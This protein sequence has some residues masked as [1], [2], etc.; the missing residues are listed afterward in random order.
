MADV[1]DVLK[2]LERLV[3]REG[4]PLFEGDIF[5][6]LRSSR[7]VIHSFEFALADGAVD[8]TCELDNSAS[9]A[10]RLW[11]VISRGQG[12]QAS[13]LGLFDV[14]STVGGLPG[15]QR[16]C[17]TRLQQRRVAFYIGISA[18]DPT[19]VEVIPNLFQDDQVL[20]HTPD[21]A[22]K[23]DDMEVRVNVSRCSRLPPSASGLLD[24]CGA[25]CRMPLAM[26]PQAMENMR[27]CL[28]S[29]GKIP[30]ENPWT[31]V[32]FPKFIPKLTT[33]VEF[34][35]SK[36]TTDHHTSFAKFQEI[37]QAVTFIKPGLLEMDLVGVQ[38][39]LGDY[40]FLIE[41]SDSLR[42]VFVQDKVDSKS[43]TVGDRLTSVAVARSRPR[44]HGKPA[45]PGYYF[46]TLE[47]YAHPTSRCHE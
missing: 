41:Q 18:S 27:R 43:R 46:T 19:F 5:S 14:K 2:T 39:R 34:L 1:D 3:V 42:Q 13:S 24:Q 20:P 31:G 37:Y 12:E 9:Y 33:N 28:Q 32:R 45:D 38:P 6:V 16:Y 15:S 26:L 7:T 11:D 8:C 25:P 21:S 36:S 4:G 22:H 23:D 40:K 35:T 47:R 44:G 30:Y 17:T 29:A 10:A